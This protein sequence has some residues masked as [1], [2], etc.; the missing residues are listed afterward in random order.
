MTRL[1]DIPEGAFFKLEHTETVFTRREFTKG[2]WTFS[3]LVRAEFVDRSGK[4]DTTFSSDLP[5]LP[6]LQ[7]P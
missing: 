1:R 5:V 6:I 2:A 4:Q 3:D 7:S